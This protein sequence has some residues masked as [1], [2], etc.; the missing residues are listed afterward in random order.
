MTEFDSEFENAVESLD[1]RAVRS[2][3]EYITVLDG[4]GGIYT[5]V[6][7]NENGSYHVDAIEGRCTCADAKYNLEPDEK[8]KHQL[9]VDYATGRR[10]VPAWVDETAIAGDLGAFVDDIASP[11]APNQPAEIATDGGEG[12]EETEGE[13]I[14]GHDIPER[15]EKAD[16]GGGE[17]TGIQEL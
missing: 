17:S 5:V 3:T 6:G 7:E 1:D 8:C 12:E 14:T 4:D 11:A 2:L 15:S 9:R 16:F 13:E 10:K